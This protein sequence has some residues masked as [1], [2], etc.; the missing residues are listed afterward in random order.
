MSGIRV[1]VLL[2]TTIFFVEI[3]ILLV[4]CRRSGTFSTGVVAA[5][6]ARTAVVVRVSSGGLDACSAELFAKV[7]DGDLKFGE[8]LKVN[9]DLGVGVS[10][11][12]GEFTVGRSESCN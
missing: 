6:A 8:V 2:C 11:V 1:A 12:Y 7:G 5:C 3:S 4:A 10:A 9:E